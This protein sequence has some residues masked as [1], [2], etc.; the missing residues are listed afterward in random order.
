MVGFDLC[1]CC[2]PFLLSRHSA[3]HA[4]LMHGQ[5]MRVCGAGCL[6]PPR[7]TCAHAPANATCRDM[8]QYIGPDGTAVGSSPLRP[9]RPP[10]APHEPSVPVWQR[11]ATGSSPSQPIREKLVA[12][13]KT[14]RAV[15]ARTVTLG[16]SEVEHSE[17]AAAELA[18][19]DGV[20][21]GSAS[22]GHL[23]ERPP[24]SA[25]GA[26][27]RGA[28]VAAMNSRQVPGS[29]G[30]PM[31]GSAQGPGVQGVGAASSGPG[32]DGER[33]GEVGEGGCMWPAGLS[34]ELNI[35]SLGLPA[36]VLRHGGCRL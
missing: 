23:G 15:A 6:R 24:F 34:A 10:R 12:A 8:G 31:A 9:S 30:T 7:A 11:L 16:L 17:P 22:A 3:S 5:G 28:V 32:A 1:R 27:V 26:W 18:A 35:G 19:P 29:S 36:C 20:S 2:Q 25:G 14:F 21:R 33:E 13:P 4:A